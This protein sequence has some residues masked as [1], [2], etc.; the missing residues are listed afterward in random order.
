VTL[1]GAARYRV[2]VVRV[3]LPETDDDTWRIEL[4]EVGRRAGG[5]RLLGRATDTTGAFRILRSWFDEI[6]VPPDT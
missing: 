4:L 3:E 2:V 1:S 5:D 6:P